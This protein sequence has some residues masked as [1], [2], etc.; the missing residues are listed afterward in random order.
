[1]PSLYLYH[2]M[3]NY[4][5]NWEGQCNR[6]KRETNCDLAYPIR[7]LFTL[8][9]DTFVVPCPSRLCLLNERL[10][11]LRRC[12]CV[13]LVVYMSITL[14]DA[15]LKRLCG[16]LKAKSRILHKTSDYSR[17]FIYK[18]LCATHIVIPIL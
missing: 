13:P 6:A 14:Y 15:H 5:Y 7:S 11:V 18:Q 8:N 9:L 1:M 12:Q 2:N 17:H 10:H 4:Q 3:F 16:Q